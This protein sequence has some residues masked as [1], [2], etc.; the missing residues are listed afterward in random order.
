MDNVKQGAKN[1]AIYELSKRFKNIDLRTGIHRG[2]ET[3]VEGIKRVNKVLENKNKPTQNKND[4][5]IT[6]KDI[7]NAPRLFVDKGENR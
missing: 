4:E 2:R 7:E 6:I 5:I 1:K 3:Y